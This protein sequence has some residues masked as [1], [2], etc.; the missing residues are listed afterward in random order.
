MNYLDPDLLR[1]FLVFADTG[2][3]ARAAEIVGRSPPA[4]TAQMQR[5]EDLV[6]ES[7]LIPS[8]RGR[9]LTLAGEELAGHARRILDAHQRAILSLKGARAE[10][11]ISLAATQDFAEGGL[12]PLLRLFATTHP[13][14]GLHLRVG[15]SVELLHAFEEGEADILVAMGTAPSADEVGVIR[16]PMVWIGSVEGLA[17]G[18]DELPLALLDAPCGFRS[19]ALSTLDQ[20]RRPYRI[21]ATSQSLSGLRTAVAAGVAVTLRTPR[22]IGPGLADAGASLQLPAAGE[23]SFSIRVRAEARPSAHSLG[24][25]IYDQL[26]A[27]A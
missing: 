26:R 25:L 5:L 21:A 15:R 8:G 17:A 20:A 18:G 24:R 3:L 14:I 27:P 1:T 22:W 11:R 23:A 12:A 2:S 13:R 16:E 7:L 6:G 9:S 10:G 4:V 19:A